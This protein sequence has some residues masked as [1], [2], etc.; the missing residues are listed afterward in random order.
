MKKTP[1]LF[2][3]LIILSVILSAC[4]PT[5]TAVKTEEAPIVAVP[6]EVVQVA[7]TEAPAPTEVPPTVAPEPALDALALFTG[8]V[9]SLP[10]DKGFGVVKAA[11]VKEELA[12]DAKP[13]LLDVRDAPEVEKDGFIEGAVNIPIRML[14]RNLDKLPGLDSPI[15]VYCGSG[16]RGGMALAALKLMGYTNVRNM[17]G[18]I[19]AWKKAEFPVVTGSMPAEPTVLTPNPIVADKALY[20]LV[21]GFLS[22]LPDDYFL[23]K[24][25][26]LAEELASATPPVVLDV[27]TIDE[28]LN[29]GYI[30]D[31]VHIPFSDFFKS[32]DQLPAKDAPIVVY[33]GSGA[34]GAIVMMGLREMGYTNVRNLAGGLNAWKAAKLPVAGVVDW[35]ATWAD[36]LKNMPEGYYTVKADVLTR[37][38]ASATPPF[39][40][41]VRET[42]EVETDGFI[43]GA[44]NLP[45]RTV[46]RNLDKLPALDQPIVIYCGSGHRGAMVMSALRLLG[47]TNVSNLSGGLNAWKK[48]TLPTE[49]G[50]PA[51]PVAGTAAD[52]DPIKLRG[53]DSFLAT[54]PDGY[55]GVKAADLQAELATDQKPFLLDVRTPEEVTA[56]GAIEGSIFVPITTLF[57][58]LDKLPTDKAAPIVVTC[59]SGHRGAIAMMALRMNGYSNVRSLFG[60]INA[61]TAAELPVV[62]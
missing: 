60:G 62:K 43:K 48:A 1:V 53:L 54:L 2:A 35:N 45:V 32:I 31:S 17:G 49:T 16:H 18:G 10:A 55:F 50:K 42:I 5:T 12:S 46:L 58:N 8:L 9:D 26:K 34:R 52:V 59:Q 38:L 4:A 7:P 6:T 14:L 19:G 3:L 21:D 27:R 47:Y 28:R 56:S 61:W 44:V 36:F 30:K 20:D 11:T 57:D 29:D 23:V 13:F 24:S 33:C 15:V 40:L 51:D 25:D 39:L 37:D 41:D 22:K